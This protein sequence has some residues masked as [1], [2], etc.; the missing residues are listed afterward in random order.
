MKDKKSINNYILQTLFLN[1][2]NLFVY[3][4][5]HMENINALFWKLMI[6]DKVY[7]K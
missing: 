2:Q 5:E 3:Y 1:R 6:K 7:K 4:R